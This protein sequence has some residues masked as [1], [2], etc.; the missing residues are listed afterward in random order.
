M[1]AIIGLFSGSPATI[2]APSFRPS[3]MT[4]GTRRS[5]PFDLFPTFW[6]FVRALLQNRR[7]QARFKRLAA[8]RTD[9]APV[10]SA[11]HLRRPLPSFGGRPRSLRSGAELPP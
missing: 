4:S 5:L 8:H 1:R 2:A 7:D 6:Q 3:K 10:V 9:G 11:A